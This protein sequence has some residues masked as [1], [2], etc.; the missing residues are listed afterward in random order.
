VESIGQEDPWFKQAA[1]KGVKVSV[2]PGGRWNKFKTYSTIQRTFEIWSFAIA[3]VFK[4]WLNNQ[5]FMYRGGMT[6]LKKKEKRKRLAKWVK[7][8][9]LRLGPTFIKIGQQF[10]TRV[11]ILAQ[12]YVDELAELQDQVP[13]FESETAVRIIETE[14][15]QPVDVIFDRFDRDPI[16]AASLGQV[17]RATFR[18]EEVVIKVQRPGLKAL[19]D[20]DLKNL[21]VRLFSDLFSLPHLWFCVYTD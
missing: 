20:I 5:K 10:S 4:A 12:E 2:V 16:A 13:P 11:D 8:G 9:L 17:H 19:F 14:L 7:E 21:R 3:F 18:G 6:E 15:G 1:S